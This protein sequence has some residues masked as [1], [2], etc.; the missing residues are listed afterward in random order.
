MTEPYRTINLQELRR[1]KANGYDLVPL[2]R[3]NYKTETPKG[4]VDRGKTPRDSN[5]LTRQYA[6]DELKQWIKDGGNVGVRLRPGDLV[7]D[8]DP[9]NV[10]EGETPLIDLA[11]D[12]GIDL[13]QC[14]TTRTGS[15]GN[16]WY[17]RMPE[18]VRVKNELPKYPGVE[19]KAFGRQVVAAGSIHPNGTFYAW[20]ND[21]AEPPVVPEALLAA[22]QKPLLAEVQGVAGEINAGDLKFC[23]DQLDPKK[24]RSHDVWL[25]IMTASHS[26]TGG[27]ADGLA[28][29]T[30]W[31]TSDPDYADAGEQIAYRWQT[32]DANEPGGVRLGTLYMHVLDA[33]GQLPRPKI[34]DVFT[35]IEQLEGERP[36][37]TPSLVR[38]DSGVPKST[39]ANASAAL[40]SLDAGW[41]YNE[42]SRRKL[43]RD[44]HWL[45]T[46]YKSATELVD[47]QALS[48][49][50][51]HLLEAFGLEVSLSTIRDAVKTLCFKD[52]VNPLR[53]WLDSLTWDG[54]PRLNQWLTLYA[55]VEPNDY[56]SAAGRATLLGAVART[57]KPG[58]KF[59][60][61]LILEGPQGTYKSTLV[62][63]LGGE[64]YM[65]GL[66][67]KDLNDKDVIA[68]LLGRWIIEI[69]EL[70]SMHKSDAE[71]FKG[72]LS[73]QEDIGRLA[74]EPDSDVFPRRCI[75]IGTTNP[76][77]SGYLRDSTG[78]RRFFPVMVGIARPNALRAERD[79]LFAEAVAEWKKDPRPEALVLPESLWGA[80]NEQQDD[81]RT[82]DPW[83]LSFAEY[84][85]KMGYEVGAKVSSAELFIIVLKKPATDSS[86][87]MY[88]RM[89]V[90]MGTLGWTPTKHVPT[91][92]GRYVRGYLKVR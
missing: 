67:N 62:T 6:A 82:Q 68:A 79:Q 42:M 92:T 43:M 35:R 76:N 69:E 89:G 37:P 88:K 53:D 12:L 21:V 90:V 48:M 73:K 57:Y 8:Y 40:I 29:F 5:W 54:T 83:E 61:M 63:I 78:N 75:F 84:I 71:S 13:S 10:P 24:F 49:L 70:S 86:I 59:D 2:N 1:Y 56:V 11:L 28:A 55:G 72:F 9:R 36:V 51:G 18:G 7:V 26:A 91:H 45:Q 39:L 77:G 17:Y 41:Y 81:R 46:T 34:E 16:H 33:E 87:E 19:F 74:Y 30:E 22:I 25:E 60:S 23:L 64:Y 4:P 31:S 38:F 15:G 47:S 66:P 3:W 14:P 58:I 50:Q 52:K 44:P 65:A 85:E 80:A 32:F 20:I 27:S